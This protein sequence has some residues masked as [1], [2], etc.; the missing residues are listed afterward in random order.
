MSVTNIQQKLQSSKMEKGVYIC[1]LT[2]AGK[3]KVQTKAQ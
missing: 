2:A 1:E 3:Y